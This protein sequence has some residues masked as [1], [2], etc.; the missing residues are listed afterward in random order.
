MDWLFTLSSFARQYSEKFPKIDPFEFSR[1]LWGDIFYN[2]R[3]RKFSRKGMEDGAKRSFVH[4]ILEPIYKLYSVTISESPDDLARTL[5]TLEISLKPTQLKSDA[6]VL[7]KLVCAQFF[8]DAGSFVDMVVQ[9]IPS[10]LAGAARNLERYYTGP[11]DS[12]VAT[13]MSKCDAD[14]PLVVQITKLY[15]YWLR[16]VRPNHVRHCVCRHPG[17]DSWRI[18]QP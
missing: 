7:L 3:S 4:W 15:N 9:H 10:P 13:A 8:G 17:P 18:L 1:R 2:P 16:C 6:K 5:E 12:S 11:A 14:G